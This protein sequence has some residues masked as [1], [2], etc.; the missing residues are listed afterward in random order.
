MLSSDIIFSLTGMA[1][2]WW[3]TWLVT[4]V[5][6]LLPTNQKGIF[7]LSTC[8]VSSAKVSTVSQHHP[9]HAGRVKLCLAAVNKIACGRG[10]ETR[11]QQ[12]KCQS[13]NRAVIFCI[14]PIPVSTSPLLFSIWIAKLPI[15]PVHWG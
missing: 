6:N 13:Q 11:L 15:F 4:S 9:A 2:C 12:K 1:M 8:W 14:F 5:Q 3:A 7:C 10:D